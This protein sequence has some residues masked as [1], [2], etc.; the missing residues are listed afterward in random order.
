MADLESQQE[1]GCRYE[2]LPQ[3]TDLG[4]Q[5]S[6]HACASL[7]PAVSTGPCISLLLVVLMCKSAF[8]DRAVWTGPSLLHGSVKWLAKSQTCWSLVCESSELFRSLTCQ[9]I[10]DSIFSLTGFNT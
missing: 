4:S 10:P 6:T 3:Q 9:S 2:H 5:I 8:M 1:G 7:L